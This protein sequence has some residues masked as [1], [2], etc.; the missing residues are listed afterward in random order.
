MKTVIAVATLGLACITAF[1]AAQELPVPQALPADEFNNILVRANE[2]L[3]IAG[4]PTEQGLDDLAA[5]GV[6][7]VVNLRTEFEMNDRSMVGFDESA[8]VADL[9]LRYVHIP[10]GGPDTPYA[11]QM[12]DRF[13]EAM[14]EAE[15]RVLLHCTVAWRASHLYTAYLYRYRGLTLNEAIRHGRAINLGN[16]PLE[17]FLGAKLS[18]DAEIVEP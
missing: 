7:T 9:G 11:A 5:A 3:F 15:G 13:A 4:Q 14:E 17:G 1:A 2:K 10:S 16:L 12:V 6:T 8:Y 18:F